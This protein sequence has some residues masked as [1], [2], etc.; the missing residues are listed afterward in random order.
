MGD[1]IYSFGKLVE[2]DAGIL[3]AGAQLRMQG[4]TEPVALC[5]KGG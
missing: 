2:Q 4:F 1:G 5:L 3:T